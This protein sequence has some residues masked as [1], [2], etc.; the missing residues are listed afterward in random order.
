MRSG[1][2]SSKMNVNENNYSDQF[3]IRCNEVLGKNISVH[4]NANREH[5]LMR[6]GEAPCQFYFSFHE[7][8]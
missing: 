2:A 1:K 8:E 3:L 4:K 5:F 6:G 7:H